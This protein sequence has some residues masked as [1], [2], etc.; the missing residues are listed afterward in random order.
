MSNLSKQQAIEVVTQFLG[1]SSPGYYVTLNARTSD[2]I[3]FTKQLN[4][5]ANWLNE[6]CYGARFRRGKIRLKIVTSPEF[7][8]FNGGLHAHLVVTHD[9]T[10]KR[11]Y[12]EINAYIR[13]KWYRLIEAKGSVFGTM[14][15]VTELYDVRGAVSYSLEDFYKYSRD[16]IK[17]TFL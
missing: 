7:G 10:M 15:D 5:I 13:K 2:V 1:E 9:T 6:Y 14:V 11:T 12:Q 3:K 4:Q 8:E 17:V 16:R